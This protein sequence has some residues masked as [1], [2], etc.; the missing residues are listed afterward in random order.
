MATSMVDISPTANGS[1]GELEDS[2]KMA[3]KKT[4]SIKE[5]DLCAYLSTDG[6]PLSPSS[7]LRLRDTDQ[8]TLLSLIREKILDND[9]YKTADKVQES[10]VISPYSGQSLEGCI[11]EA[12]TKMNVLRDT[13]LCKY[14]PSEEGYLHHFTFL[15]MKSANPIQLRNLIKEHILDRTPKLIPPKR[16]KTYKSRERV[17]DLPI[18]R[19]L[20][21]K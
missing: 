7:Y 4:G 11:K 9:P 14:I 13:A 21:H 2:I 5:F 10:P 17:E 19:A 18:S 20:L 6:K 3:L 16:R 15:K 1:L 8:S 12:M